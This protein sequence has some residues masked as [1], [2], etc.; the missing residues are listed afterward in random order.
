MSM[1]RDLNW[2]FERLIDAHDCE[3]DRLLSLG[4]GTK[5]DQLDA[6]TELA[7]IV[8]HNRDDRVEYLHGFMV[9]LNRAEFWGMS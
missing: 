1:T 3:F 4:V 8:A 9:R 7:G 5:S 6:I 2:L